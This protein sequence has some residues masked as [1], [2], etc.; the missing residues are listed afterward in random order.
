MKDKAIRKIVNGVS[1]IGTKS[2]GKINAL[3]AA[4]ISR[5]SFDPL[6][7]MV[8]I[9][10]ERYTLGMI[11]ESK[12]FSVNILGK[13]Q[14]ELAKHFGF[15]SGRNVNKFEKIAY[16][17]G[18]TGSPLLKDCVARMDCEVVSQHKAGDHTIFIGKVVD[19]KMLS[20]DEP[21]AYNHNDYQSE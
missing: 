20:E 15:K 9:G 14:I 2:K 21:L 1:I 3:T 5:A 8:S 16:E 19:E 4:W 6:L 13:S 10:E 11:K 12:V 7:V 17:A 18:K